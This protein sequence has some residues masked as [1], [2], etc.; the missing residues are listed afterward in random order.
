MSG[1]TTEEVDG[2]D[3]TKV[4]DMTKFLPFG[5]TLR[6]YLDQT[7]VKTSDLSELLRGRGVFVQGADKEDLIPILVTTLIS[8]SEFQTLLDCRKERD[9]KEKIINRTRT[10]KSSR[11]LQEAADASVQLENLDF[12]DSEKCKLIGKLVITS[13]GG[14]PNSIEVTFTIQRTKMS[15]DWC[16]EDSR[17]I[18]KVS[19]KKEEI[20]GK[21]VVSITHTSPETKDIAEKIAKLVEDSLKKSGDIGEPTS[22]DRILF[23]SFDNVQRADFFM[24]FTGADGHSGLIFERSTHLDALTV[25]GVEIPESCK[26]LIEGLELLKLRG[27][28]HKCAYLRKREIYPFIRFYRMDARFKFIVP[29]AEGECAVRY[30]FADYGTSKNPSAE[31]THEVEIASLGDKFKHVSKQ[32]V[33]KSLQELIARIVAEKFKL[34]INTPPPAEAKPSNAGTLIAPAKKASAKS[35]GPAT[36][37]PVVEPLELF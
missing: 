15:L 26:E 36:L 4:R 16:N 31:F 7:F 14:D 32:N 21:I 2:D 20:D 37:E 23:S 5:E 25:T 9:S 27:E 12:V 18:G 34:R 35:K 29:G 19:L 11:S 6:R 3:R 33:K 13:V 22:D 28:L 8:P 1:N 30:E 17:Y 24:S 10:W